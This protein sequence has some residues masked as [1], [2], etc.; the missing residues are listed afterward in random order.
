MKRW[1]ITF[2]CLKK[3]LEWILKEEEEDKVESSFLK[4]IEAIFDIQTI[5]IIKK[6]IMGEDEFI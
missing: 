5:E 2:V 3:E 1:R 4:E 6:E